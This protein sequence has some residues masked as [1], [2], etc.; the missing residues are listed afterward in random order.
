MDAMPAM[1]EEFPV[2]DFVCKS[3]SH[4]RSGDD[5][6]ALA[7]LLGPF[8]TGR[9]DRLSGSNDGKLR[10][11]IHETECFTG[12]VRFGVIAEYRG[13]VLEPDLAHPHLGDRPDVFWYGSDS[14]STTCK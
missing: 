8:D 2:T 14:G 5:R 13:A 1:V 10:E 9:C 7:Q 3:A 6:R 4:A 11:A 12:K